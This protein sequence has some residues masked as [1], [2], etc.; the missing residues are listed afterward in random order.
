MSENAD[1]DRLRLE[2]LLLFCDAV[3]AI[4]IT[5][6]VLEI[7]VPLLHGPSERQLADSLLH[8]L[9]KLLGYVVSFLVVGTY[10]V[11]HHK[12]FSLVESYAEPLLWKNL[13]LLLCVAFIPFPTAFFSEYL[14]Y[15]TSLILYAAS[16]ALL[17]FSSHALGRFVIH[18]ALLD[19]SASESEVRRLNR[20]T[21]GVPVIC[22]LAIGLSFFSLPA[23]RLA[24]MLIPAVVWWLGRPLSR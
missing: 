8:L 4:A 11:K 2:R 20:S 10:W 14:A 22:L 17:G 16:L 12:L 15:Q 24:L 19:P 9:P 3:F 7:K 1:P 13:R 6:L 18:A 5:L 21:L 23:A